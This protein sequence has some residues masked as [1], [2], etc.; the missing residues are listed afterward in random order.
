MLRAAATADPSDADLPIEI[1]I[2]DKYI[3]KVYYDIAKE[4]PIDMLE[5]EKNSY[6]DEW[7]NY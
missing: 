2:M 6:G 7:R 3:P 5:T 1:E 4:I